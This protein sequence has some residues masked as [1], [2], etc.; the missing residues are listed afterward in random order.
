WDPDF[1]EFS[2][3]VHVYAFFDGSDVPVPVSSPV[4]SA[5]GFRPDVNRAFG[6]A[7]DH[8]FSRVIPIRSGNHKVCA[9]SVGVDSNGDL[10]GAFRNRLIGCRQVI[11]E[12]EAAPSGVV[13]KIVRSGA[14]VSVKGWA[15]DLD[16][17]I[18]PVGIHVYVDGVPTGSGMTDQ[19][20]A[21]VNKILGVDGEHGFDLDVSV[22]S[23]S[24]TICAYVLGNGANGTQDGQNVLLRCEDV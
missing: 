1:P 3:V 22:T 20:R 21:D 17:E 10:E 7:G 2:M 24:H 19:V 5:A 13:D 18:Q 14:V 23:G 12:D 16:T 4:V 9:Y 15:Y 8:G 6:I 11:I